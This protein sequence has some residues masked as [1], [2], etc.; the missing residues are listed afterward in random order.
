MLGAGV[1][2]VAAVLVPFSLRKREPHADAVPLHY[3]IHGDREGDRIVEKAAVE[4]APV[5]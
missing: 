3:E 4:E 2:W 1:L 5:A